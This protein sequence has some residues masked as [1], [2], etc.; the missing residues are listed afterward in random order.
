MAA[1]ALAWPA[2][3]NPA[4]PPG[5]ARI[6]DAPTRTSAAAAATAAA[7]RGLGA[8][9]GS[10]GE[11]A[12]VV[13]ADGFAVVHVAGH[14]YKVTTDDV[15]YIDHAEGLSVGDV[16][17]LDRVLMLGSASGGTR[18]GT[19]LVSQD[20]V[21][22]EAVVEQ[23]FADAKITTL[24]MRRRKNSR[25]TTNSRPRLTALRILSIRFDHEADRVTAIA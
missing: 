11:E 15:V 10:A 5:V 6:V 17:R 20:L 24:K 8:K 1:E 19:P 25:R 22:V 23:K 14:Q 12:K 21:R 2:R 7:A 4:M 3:M 18:V 9:V 13:K 16:V